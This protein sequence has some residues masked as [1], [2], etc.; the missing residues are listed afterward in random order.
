[1][2]WRAIEYDFANFLRSEECRELA[3]AIS[4]PGACVP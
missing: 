3:E 2:D 1:M 4:W